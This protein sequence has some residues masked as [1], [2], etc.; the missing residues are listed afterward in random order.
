MA[1]V[2]ERQPGVWEV[3]VFTGNN[4]SGRPTQVSRTV[5]GTKRDALRAAAEMTL[6][7]SRAAGRTVEVLVGEW[8]AVNQAT[9]A[10]ATARDQI[11]RVKLINADPIAAVAIARLSPADI[12][13]W[14]GRM[15]K[16]GVGEGAIR[17]RHIV[18]RAA[19][20]QGVRWGWLTTNPASAARLTQR[21][22]APR[23][24]M[25]IED[26]QAVVLAA[27]KVDAGAALAL[28]LA[29][30]TGARRSELAALRWDDLTGSRLRIDSSVAVI[31]YGTHAKPAEPELVDD[32]TKTANHRTVTVDEV[33]VE[34]W[35]AYR[36]SFAD[37]G[38]WVFGRFE[39]ANPDRISWWWKRA[40][41]Q[42]RI[43]S[44]WRL[45]DLRHWSATYAIGGG[46]DVRTVAGRLGHAN[47]AM[48]LRVY[49]HVLEQADQEVAAALARTLDTVGPRLLSQCR[50]QV[51]FGIP[52]PLRVDRVS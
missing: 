20:S 5:R 21:K 36:A 41:A 25:S 28:R 50:S 12:E 29:A 37:P 8:L 15:R 23:Q 38:D 24:A 48:T 43:S 1:T 19:L 26:V 9:W 49:A 47:A 16:S 39:P 51:L 3:R 34:L 10:P 33:T 4:D 14:H 40:R 30:V 42:S 18:L 52:R 44:A 11:S 13:H 27:G 22:R 2:R 35:R 32:I 46:H 31:R 6:K 7:P 17:N 45:H